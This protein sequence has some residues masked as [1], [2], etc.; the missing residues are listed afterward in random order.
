MFILLAQSVYD[1]M[2]SVLLNFSL[3]RLLKARQQNWMGEDHLDFNQRGSDLY[4]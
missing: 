1:C 2:A 4:G 3:V